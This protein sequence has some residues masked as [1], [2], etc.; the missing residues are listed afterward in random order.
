[1]IRKKM[2]TLLVAVMAI[3]AAIPGTQVSAMAATP[4]VSYQ[5]HIQNKG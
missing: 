4:G 3:A 5:A 2:A 1:M